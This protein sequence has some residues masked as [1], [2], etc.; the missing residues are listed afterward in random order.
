MMRFLMMLACTIF[1]QIPIVIH[2]MKIL[3]SF[4]LVAMVFACQSE[5]QKPIDE[6]AR[7]KEI[8]DSTV[9]AFQK[10]RFQQHVDSVFSN[11]RFNGGISISKKSKIINEKF[12]G[13]QDF[14]SKTKLDSNSV[15]AIGSVSKQFT[16]ALVLLQEEAGKLSTEDKVSK[17]LAD[18]KSKPF[19]KITIAQLL[20]HTSGISDSGS[21]LLSPPGQ[22][23]HYSNKGYR[24]LGELV[25]N[26]SGKPLDQNFEALFSK[27]KMIHSSTANLFSHDH[28]AGAYLGTP[29]VFRKVENMPKRLASRQISVAAGG[30]LSTL[31]DLH[32]WNFALFNGHILHPNSLKKMLTKS[33]EIQHPILGKVGYGFGIMMNVGKPISYFHTGYVKGSPSLSIYYPQSK[34]SVV[35]LSNIADESKGKN[36]LFAPHKALKKMVDTIEN[37][38]VERFPAINP[39]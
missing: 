36:A 4:L 17:Y 27:A 34:T 38:V 6:A 16:A 29:V 12:N 21:G 24:F 19:E 15:F 9:L 3:F 33:S 31:S 2:Y 11:S 22:Q 30:V 39:E 13:F 37:A 20:N 7:R 25:A 23:F 14:Q 35:I 26:V 8:M 28:F 5:K 32:R 1:I 10:T 18:F